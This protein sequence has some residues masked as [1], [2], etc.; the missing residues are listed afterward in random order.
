MRF[1]FHSTELFRSPSLSRDSKE[2]LPGQYNNPIPTRFPAPI[3][4]Y[5]STIALTWV[6]I[7]GRGERVGWRR[8]SS[9]AAL[10]PWQSAPPSPAAP[11]PAAP[12]H[13]T[14]YFTFRRNF[15][16]NS[17]SK[18]KRKLPLDKDQIITMQADAGPMIS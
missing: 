6:G 18:R 9:P 17:N 14:L 8:G 4:C 11:A 1:Q 10:A 2:P 16:I 15:L 5:S 12:K 3:D 7:C 13:A